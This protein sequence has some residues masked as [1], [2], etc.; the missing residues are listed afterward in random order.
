M[1]IVKA[2]NHLPEWASGKPMKVEDLYTDIESQA[3]DSHFAVILNTEPKKSWL[4]EHPF[5]K[6]VSYIP[7]SKL[8][9]M[10]SYFF[11][12]WYVEIRDTKLLANSLVVTVRVH[13]KKALKPEGSEQWHWTDGVGAVPIQVNKD[14]GATDFLQMKANAVQIGLPAAES[15]AFKD[16]VEKLGRIFGKDLNR[17]DVLDYSVILGTEDAPRFVA[18]VAA[19]APTM[20]HLNGG[21]E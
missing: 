12:D 5:A 2:E 16:A 17:K 18:P 15:Y 14:A 7:I 20:A 3:Y 11:G 9:F 10:M 4:K 6:G 1:E 8:E 13:Y 19:E 21:V